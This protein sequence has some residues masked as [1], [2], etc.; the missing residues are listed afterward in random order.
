MENSLL[1]TADLLGLHDAELYLI[2]MNREAKSLQ[3]NFRCVGKQI[4]KFIFNEVLTYKINNV[5]YQNVVSR[6]LVSNANIQFDDD[7]DQVVRWTCSGSLNDLLIS[8]D[9]LR[10]HISNIRSSDLQF[11]CV[12][13]SWGAEVG[14]IAKS[15]SV[16]HESN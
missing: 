8:E 10:Q 4:Y 9:N 1:M 7:L 14:V 13:A 6:I 16:S 12:E 15:I 2:L 3:L 5:Q 11:F